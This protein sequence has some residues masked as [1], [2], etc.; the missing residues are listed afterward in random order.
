MHRRALLTIISTTIITLVIN[1]MFAQDHS[2]IRLP[3]PRLDSDFSVEKAMLQRRSVREYS[4]EALTLDQVAQLLWACQGVTSDRGF[5]TAPSAGAL[6][7]LEV[8]AF[9]SSVDSLE[10]GVYRYVQGASIGEHYLDRI[11][12]GDR[13]TELADA[14]LGQDCIK[15]AALNVVIGAVVQRTA[16]KYGARAEQ[17]VL[18]EMGHAAQNV[19]LQAQALGLGV[20]T[21]GAMYDEK[22][23]QVIGSEAAPKY[24]LCVGRK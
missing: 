17:Y 20:V 8:F 4:D 7:P 19:C 3:E 2:R 16:V 9:V 6:Y 5:R 11:K 22:V 24:I 21:V 12:E 18:M 23:K 10:P 14:A 1:N 15:D 13:K